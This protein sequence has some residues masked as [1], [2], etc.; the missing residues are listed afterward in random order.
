MHTFWEIGASGH[1][2]TL[3]QL[4][5]NPSVIPKYQIHWLNQDEND[6][7]TFKSEHFLIETLLEGK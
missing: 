2:S 6:I 4:A 5:S 7:I 3:D 1:A